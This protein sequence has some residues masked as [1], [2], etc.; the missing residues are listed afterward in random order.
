MKVLGVLI[1]AAGLFA[2]AIAINTLAAFVVVELIGG[3][4]LS[5][6][7]ALAVLG[8]VPGPAVERLVRVAFQS[9]FAFA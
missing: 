8:G 6:R 4:D 5:F 2:L 1:A 9:P 3:I 7:E